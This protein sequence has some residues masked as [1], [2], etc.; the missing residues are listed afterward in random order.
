MPREMIMAY[1]ILKKAAANAD[2]AGNR[3]N[4]RVH[5]LIA[6]TRTWKVSTT[7]CF[8]LHVWMTGC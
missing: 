1:A 3:L 4:D 5:E 7:I 8:A 6:A 2:H